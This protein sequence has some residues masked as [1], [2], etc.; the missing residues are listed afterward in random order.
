MLGGKLAHF[1]YADTRDQSGGQKSMSAEGKN[2]DILRE[3]ID[4]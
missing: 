1:P 3:N 4:T 2:I